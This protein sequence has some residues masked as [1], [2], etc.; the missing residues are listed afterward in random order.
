MSSHYVTR[1]K[2][3]PMIISKFSFY[4]R[5]A[6]CRAKNYWYTETVEMIKLGNVSE[7]FC[8][9]N[10]GNWVIFQ[11]RQ[12][13]VPFSSP[14]SQRASPTLL[15]EGRRSSETA[16]STNIIANCNVVNI[17]QTFFVLCDRT[18]NGQW[19]SCSTRCWLPFKSLEYRVVKCGSRH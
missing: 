7:R 15:E 3:V 1:D 19:K 4:Q 11:F 18:K 2:S 9:L 10:G 8:E 17:E 13:R 12:N 16:W 6:A 5:N 14:I